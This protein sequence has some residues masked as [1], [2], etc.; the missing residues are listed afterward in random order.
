MK[1]RLDGVHW[2]EF[3]ANVKHSGNEAAILL[4]DFLCTTIN[5]HVPTIS[6]EKRN[7]QH[8]WLDN[9]C[10]QAFRAKTDSIGTPAFAARRDFCSQLFQQKYW[11]RVQ[12]TRQKRLGN[13]IG[14]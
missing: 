6:V 10:I 1:A 8:P 2:Q 3:F 12:T 7:S 9:E 4:S 5:K 14:R 11:N 13:R